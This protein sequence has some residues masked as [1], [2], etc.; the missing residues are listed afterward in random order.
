MHG[1]GKYF[2]HQGHQ[3]FEVKVKRVNYKGQKVKK[4]KISVENA[5]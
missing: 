1:C 5:H 2:P 4:S 3:Q